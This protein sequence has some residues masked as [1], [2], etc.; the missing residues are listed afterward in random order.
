MEDKWQ[1]LQSDIGVFSDGVFGK[2]DPVAKLRHLAE[3]V[4]ELIEAP[5]DRM[6]WA[7]CTI[8]LIDAARKAGLSMDDLHKAARDKLEINKKRKWG[9]PNAAGIVNHIRQDVCEKT[10]T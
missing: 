3:E 5:Q 4:Q 9:K 8:L 7:D 6:E 2:S 1:E 10:G